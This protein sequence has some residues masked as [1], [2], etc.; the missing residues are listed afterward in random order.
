MKKLV[1]IMLVLL[2][3]LSLVACKSN[4]NN[5]FAFFADNPTIEKVI[6]EYGDNYSFYC[7]A[8]NYYTAIQDIQDVEKLNSVGYDLTYENIDFNGKSGTL[9]IGCYYSSETGHKILGVSWTISKSELG[10]SESENF[11]DKIV[12]QFDSQYGKHTVDSNLLGTTYTWTDK[13]G[14]KY[15]MSDSLTIISIWM[16]Q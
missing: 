7:S 10:E 9:Y 11:V 12:N 8:N 4:S 1:L 16:K 15:T 14:I 6:K 13:S 5:V 2:F 3:V